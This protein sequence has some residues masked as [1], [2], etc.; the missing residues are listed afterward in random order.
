MQNDKYKTLSKL[1]KSI[2]TIITDTIYLNTPKLFA[3]SLEQ[4][5]QAT[6]TV[7]NKSGHGSGFFVSED[8]YIITNYHVITDTN[9][10]E[11]ITSEGVK[12]PAKVE[13]F[14]KDYD[15]ALLKIEKT[16]MLP[17]SL[18]NLTTY[19]MGKDVYIIG[20]PSAEDL[21]QTLTRGIVSSVRKSSNGSKLIQTDASINGGSSGGPM[22]NKDGQLIGVA[23]AKLVGT[24]IEGIAFGIPE[25]EIFRALVIVVR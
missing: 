2:E 18:K 22:I 25:K 24:G 1:E 10:L 8:G 23:N 16:G 3:K 14:N 4:A 17:F 12:Y 6:M 13:R 15:L 7:K 20:T 19:G 11:I 21:S 5:A 9:K